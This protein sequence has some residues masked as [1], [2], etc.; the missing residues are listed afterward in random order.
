MA[1]ACSLYA[2]ACRV[3]LALFNLRRGLPCLF[4]GVCG[5]LAAY[6]YALVLPFAAWPFIP[7]FCPFACCSGGGT[8]A[9]LHRYLLRFF[10]VCAYSLANA[11]CGAR[12]LCGIV[13]CGIFCGTLAKARGGGRD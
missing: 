7:S 6:L 1:S 2:P 3:D 8:P 9:A 12:G 10:C 4:F 11:W 5:V 13:C